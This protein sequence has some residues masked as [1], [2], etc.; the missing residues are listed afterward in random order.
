MNF[1]PVDDE[2]TIAISAGDQDAGHATP[3]SPVAASDAFESHRARGLD[4]HDVAGPERAREPARRPPR[5]R[6]RPDRARRRRSR[7][8]AR[9][10]RPATSTPSS[11]QLRR[12]RGGSRGASSPELGH[13]A[14]HRDAARLAG[15][16]ARGAE[17]R[18]HRE[19]VRVVGVVDQRARRRGAAL[20]AAPARELDRGRALAGPVE[21]QAER[22]VRRERGERVRGWCRAVQV[23]ADLAAAEVDVRARSARS[24]ADDVEPAATRTIVAGRR[25]GTA[26]AAARRPAR[27]PSPPGGS[28]SSS[29][30]LARA[31]PLD[32]ADQLEVRRARRR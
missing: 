13:L 12:P 25:A 19:R 29:S 2:M 9:R 24:S 5:P 18:A 32:R 22:V 1:G 6:P 15:A 4:E 20:L 14:E 23:E 8:R 30:A 17:R 7:G 3:G 26:R 27:P 11:A 28:A 21:R 31:T 10:P 16:L